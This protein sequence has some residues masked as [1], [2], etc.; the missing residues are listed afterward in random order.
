MFESLLRFTDRRIDGILKNVIKAF[1]MVNNNMTV[2]SVRQ[3][4]SGVTDLVNREVSAAYADI[5][6]ET[7]KEFRG[8]YPDIE[9]SDEMVKKLQDMQTANALAIEAVNDEMRRTAL[10]ITTLKDA[11][12]INVDQYREQIQIALFKGVGARLQTEIETG[13]S[14]FSQT[15]LAELGTEAGL[16]LY[17]YFGVDDEKTREFCA[18]HIGEVKTLEEWSQIDNGQNGPAYPFHGG[19][20]CRHQLIPVA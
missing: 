1:G 13:I 6:K 19:Y 4:L 15:V 7:L 2:A 12:F 3:D 9:F 18:D 10:R 17:E 11:D 5:A 8:K 20:N 14:V 16:E